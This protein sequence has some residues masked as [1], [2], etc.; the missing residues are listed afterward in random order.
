[1]KIDKKELIKYFNYGNPLNSFTCPH[2]NTFCNLESWN[3]KN[4]KFAIDETIKGYMVSI[5]CPKCKKT[6]SYFVT[7]RQD[8]L[9]KYEMHLS[10]KQIYPKEKTIAKPFPNYVPISLINLYEEMCDLYPVNNNAT[11]IWARKWVEKFIAIESSGLEKKELEDKNLEEKIDFFNQNKNT[12]LDVSI[13]TAL[14]RIGN[15][16]I[17]IFSS[18]ED[19]EISCEDASLI[20]KNIEYLIKYFYIVPHEKQEAE[21]ALRALETTVVNKSKELSKQ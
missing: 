16:T 14:R 13:L 2:C 19:I 6:S 10:I 9:D 7:H 18:Y 12:S 21:D 20:I 3:L 5:Y 15:K 1:M 4:L 17:H 11:A 8:S